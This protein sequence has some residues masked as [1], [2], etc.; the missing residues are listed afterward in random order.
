LGDKCKFNGCKKCGEKH[1]TLLHDKKT[2]E[3]TAET[4][5]STHATRSS[6]KQVLLSTAIIKIEGRSKE[7][8]YARA[9]LDSGSQCNFV[10]NDL[11][12]KLQLQL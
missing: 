1:N 7:I 3:I 10:T 12:Q 8:F 4:S 5:I 6:I 2:P 11:A 9:L